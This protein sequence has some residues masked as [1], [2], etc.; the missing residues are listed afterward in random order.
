MF[1]LVNLLSKVIR[2]YNPEGILLSGG[3]DSSLLA[4]I[5]SKYFKIYSITAIFNK[6][7][8]EKY[9][10]IVSKKLGIKH[11][12]RK[13]GLEEAI[14]A[15]RDI[16]KITKTFDHIEIR[17]DISIYI[18][19][20]EFKEEGIRKVITGDGGDELFAGYDYMISMNR[21]ELSKYTEFLIKNWYF[22]SGIIGK[23][24]GIEIIQPF[25]NEEIIE[26]AKKIPYE[27]KINK[28]NGK[29]YGKWILRCILD[30]FGFS[31]IA[32]RDKQPIEIGSGSTNISSILL[33]MLNKEEVEEI[34]KEAL[35]ENIRFWD[36]E[37]IYFFKL[38]KEIF[39]LPPKAKEN[40]KSCP[41]CKS[42]VNG[43]RCKYCG[44]YL[45]N[46]DI[47]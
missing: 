23:A 46:K 20:K 29:V 22:S 1:E 36:R 17:N 43:I 19:L 26:F 41:Y 44:F 18:A 31:E 15:I 21:E 11:K 7:D 8:D 34:E 13:Y 14:N 47:K 38:Y 33:K 28:K 39:G 42:P 3:I 27:W 25:L 45:G 32:W 2:S 4:I 9:S 40:E 30:N 24:L 12:I 37:Q 10:V 5:T 35:K 6:G 16:I